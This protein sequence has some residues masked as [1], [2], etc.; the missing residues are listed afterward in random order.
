MVFG[1]GRRF[2]K[3]VM[4][5]WNVLKGKKWGVL[6]VKRIVL[7]GVE[8]YIGLCDDYDLFVFSFLRLVCFKLLKIC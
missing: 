3:E 1:Y 2:C 5:C 6:R 4:S 7:C 8:V